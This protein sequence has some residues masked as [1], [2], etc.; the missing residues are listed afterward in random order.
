MIINGFLLKT[1]NH[2]NVF[3]SYI[4]QN[5][6]HLDLDI[7]LKN[8]YKNIFKTQKEMKHINNLQN[9]FFPTNLPSLKKNPKPIIP[10]LKDFFIKKKDFCLEG[11]GNASQF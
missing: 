10:F 8:I 3:F 5:Y 11:T 9:F 6:F 2:Y 4:F 1:K 7:S